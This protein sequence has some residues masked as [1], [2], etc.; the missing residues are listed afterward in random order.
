MAGLYDRLQSDDEDKITIHYMKC[1]VVFVQTGVVPDAAAAITKLNNRLPVA[2][3]A[4]DQT[5]VTNIVTQL[6]AKPTL[7]DKL[8]Y[9]NTCEAV[10]EATESKDLTDGQFRSTL[11][12]A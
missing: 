3:G 9:I 1:V 7:A 11:G 2:L 12:I 5:D 4:Q 10:F 8:E 6:N